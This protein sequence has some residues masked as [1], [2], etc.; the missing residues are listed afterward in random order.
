MVQTMVRVN[1]KLRQMSNY[2][3]IHVVFFMSMLIFIILE[4]ASCCYTVY[5][6]DTSR[7]VVISDEKIEPL[8]HIKG[9]D[10]TY[11]YRTK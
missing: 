6:Y 1:V 7:S 10:T 5:N 4:I 11:I 9:E 8:I 2:V 3:R